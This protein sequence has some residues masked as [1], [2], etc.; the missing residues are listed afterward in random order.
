MD[1]RMQE[2]YW[3]VFT[4]D[5]ASSLVLPAGVEQVGP[6]ETVDVTGLQLTVVAGT[7]F[8]AYPTLQLACEGVPMHAA[9]LP[10]AVE[11]AL[12]GEHQLTHGH[13]LPAASAQ[14]VYLRNNVAIA[15]A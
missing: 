12:L 2:V 15:K 14:P 1:A 7:G 9:L 11:I 3:S 6:P 5:A 10:S 8:N 13:G 4:V